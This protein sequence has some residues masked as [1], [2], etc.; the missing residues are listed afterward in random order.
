MKRETDIEQVR[1]IARMLLMKDVHETKYSPNV[2]QHPIISYGVVILPGKNAKD[3]R[4]IDIT[5][6]RENRRTWQKAVS[7]AIP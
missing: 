7:A 2:I 5:Q 6:N 3:F 4:A 1:L